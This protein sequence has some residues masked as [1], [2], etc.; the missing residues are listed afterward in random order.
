MGVGVADVAA[1]GD[2]VVVVVLLLLFIVDDG[3]VAA[4]VVDC[5]VFVAFSF[6]QTQT[7]SV[8]WHHTMPWRLATGS[9]DRTVKIWDLDERSGTRR[10]RRQKPAVME[11]TLKP[12]LTLA[13]P[14]PVRGRW[15]SII[16]GVMGRA[17]TGSKRALMM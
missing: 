16:T 11:Q 4:A 2:G 3:V 6:P 12:T 17:G 1:V 10:D 5:T 15:S 13:S 7:I 14:A 8:E 9:H